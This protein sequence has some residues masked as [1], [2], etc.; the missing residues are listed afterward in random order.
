M[1]ERFLNIFLFLG[2]LAMMAAG[3]IMLFLQSN[4]LVSQLKN[5]I[6]KALSTAGMDITAFIIAFLGSSIFSWGIFFFL[7]SVYTV[8]ELKNN[9]IYGFI[10]WGYTFW[11]TGCVISV[12]L[13][14][15]ISLP[16]IILFAILYGII[17]IP[18][19]LSLPMKKKA[20]NSTGNDQPASTTQPPMP[21]I[22]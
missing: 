21:P 5:I 2:S 15:G 6:E 1:K 14:V 9:A 18:F 17:F 16:L 13:Y 10:F 19:F 4:G 12:I 22:Q 8:M 7:L 20:G 3:S 11:I